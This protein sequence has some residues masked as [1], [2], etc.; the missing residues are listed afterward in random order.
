MEENIKTTAGQGFGIAALVLGILALITAPIPCV[1]LLALIPGII[2]IVFAIIALVQAGQGKSAKGLIITALVL[3]ALGTSIATAWVLVFS[4]SPFL[5]APFKKIM[6][7]IK[8]DIKQNHVITFEKAIKE[9]N[10]KMEKQLEELEGTSDSLVK[11]LEKV[12]EPSDTEIEI[13]D[14]I[15]KH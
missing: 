6:R 9:S 5:P 1:G 12:E 14:T 15:Q 13:K 2:G 3:S 7:D 11:K 10:R 4:V 8:K